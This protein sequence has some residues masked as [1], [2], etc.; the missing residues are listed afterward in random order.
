MRDGWACIANHAEARAPALAEQMRPASAGGEDCL[1]LR[2][3][4]ARDG[5]SSAAE[6]MGGLVRSSRSV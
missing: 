4:K 1:R 3:S 6:H 5:T 2:S